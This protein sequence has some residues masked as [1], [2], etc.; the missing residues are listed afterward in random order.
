MALEWNRRGVLTVQGNIW[1]PRRVTDVLKHPRVAGLLAYQ[2]NI[3]GH[4]ADVET[5][6]TREE[7]EAL[8]AQVDALKDSGGSQ[9]VRTAS[10]EEITAEWDSGD[11]TT[12]RILIRRVVSVGPGPARG[13]RRSAGRCPFPMPRFHVSGQANGG[14]G[15][16]PD[17][18]DLRIRAQGVLARDPSGSA[19]GDSRLP[20]QIGARGAEPVR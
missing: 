19:G 5:I 3:V 15:R 8:V 12:R 4:L 6:I 13:P 11:T 2:G 9:A 18:P 16:V 10:I 7:H 14:K 1:Q 17:R 20:V